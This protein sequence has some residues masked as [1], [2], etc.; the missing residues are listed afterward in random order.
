[1][2]PDTVSTS[3]AKRKP[4][5]RPA[6]SG[7]SLGQHFL[8]DEA[9]LERIVRAV[10]L[11][12]DDPVL[13]IGPGLGALTKLLC[14][15]ALRVTAVE[16]DPRFEPPLRKLC[17]AFPNL[18]LIFADFLRLDLA[19]L[20]A[21]AFGPVRGVVAANIPYYISTAIL[22][23]LLASTSEWRRTVLLV[24]REFAA[25][26]AAAP[27]GK[28]Y[29]ALS[30]FVQFTTHAELHGVVPR[31][32]FQP[33]PE[34]DSQIVTLTPHTARAVPVEHETLFFHVVR[35][36]FGQR[37]KT[38]LNALVRAPASFGLGLALDDR[39]ECASILAAAGID[40]LRRGETLSIA[41]FA[42][43]TQAFLAA[44]RP[45]ESDVPR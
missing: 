21:R 31:T 7:K 35:A 2:A 25:R 22:E 23:R 16:V 41:E 34:V 29:G 19:D 45:I 8:R 43:L 26:M 12:P 40:G 1:M 38:L 10:D 37:R 30:V 4:L 3:S 13:E 18:D 17:E 39:D 42:L 11:T 14:R 33:A 20:L 27:G 15:D 36:A 24:Q 9:A 6:R 32:A 5:P 44:G 28:E